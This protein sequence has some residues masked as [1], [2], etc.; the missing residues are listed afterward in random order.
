MA[1]PVGEAAW[2]S[3]LEEQIR[4]A[5]DL[6]QRVS[7]VEAFKRSTAA[8]PIS[9][10]LWLAYCS[11]IL[12]LY[13]DSRAEGWD[14]EEA[15]LGQQLFNEETVTDSW[16]EA[17]EA[18]KFRLS[19]SHLLWN[20]WIEFELER[21]E[22]S[23]TDVDTVR[24][25]F[26]DR[27]QVPQAAWD[28]T[29]RLFSN[30]V[31]KYDEAAYEETMVNATKGAAVGKILFSERETKEMAITRGDSDEVKEAMME[32]LDWEIKQ[33]RKKK[34]P[35]PPELCFALYERALLMFGTTV[36]LW[37]DYLSFLTTAIHHFF[38]NLNIL[39]VLERATKYCPSSGELWA[40]LLLRM[41]VE[42]LPATEVEHK[43]DLIP[44]SDLEMP[45]VILV[46]SAWLGY[47]RRSGGTEA[48][49]RGVVHS[50]RKEGERR[51]GKKDYKGDPAFTLER[52][53][54]QY[55]TE[56]KGDHDAARSEWKKLV[57]ARGDGYDFWLQYY[58]WELSVGEGS[59]EVAALVLASAVSR[60]M[61][62]W[63]EKLLEVYSR[64]CSLYQDA[65]TLETSLDF[66]FK[67]MKGVAKRRQKEAL[68]YQQQEPATMAVDNAVDESTPTSKRKR[69][70]FTAD[71]SNKKS[72]IAET[73]VAD[74]GGRNRESTSVLVTNLPPVTQTKVKLFFKD[75]GHINTIIMKGDK[76]LIEFRSIE[77][78][79]SAL[80]RN[81]K[82]FNQNQIQVSSG[83][84]LTLY[85]TNY[86]PT[87]DDAFMHALFSNCGE[88]FSIRWPSLK[89]N[90]HRRF[91]Y[92]SFTS[93][94]ATQKAIVE[95]DGKLLENGK[96]KLEVKY[97]DPTN[98]KS[99][100]GA[101]AEGRE[102]HIGSLD[103]T[104][105][106]DEISEIM[107]KYGKVESVRI[108]RNMAGNSK[109]GAF[110]VFSTQD[111]AKL[112]LEL[113]NTKFKSQ[114]LTVEL[115]TG[116]N[117][118]PKATTTSMPANGKFEKVS[119]AG[120]AQRT[121]IVRNI[122]DTVNDARIKA[123]AES[124]GAIVIKLTLRP[125][126]TGA[127]IELADEAMAGKVSL[128]LDGRE[129]DGKVLQVGA[130]PTPK[131]VLTS[132]PAPISV[133]AFM[134]QSSAPIKRPRALGGK[135]GRGG[136]AR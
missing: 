125:D 126:I 80:L 98:K 121:V 93:T 41:E 20:R 45:N 16:R 67:N 99:R 8:E 81:D 100:E 31:S 23:T 75:Y 61:L 114:I 108:L 24:K 71:V 76:A 70:E 59:Q 55:L 35:A 21:L 87:A 65:V 82:Y 54:I 14:E 130:P 129:L 63:P 95:L 110:V 116:I 74:I 115:S 22:K 83:Y 1:D 102:V 113:N 6:E 122:P 32:Y 66:A 46:Y 29:S 57:S 72:K 124:F 119:P 107:S 42:G 40:R 68:D 39:D 105:T 18:T 132:P 19:D 69:E 47:L 58:D 27:L 133:P 104:A 106:E 120:I 10:S 117:Y 49:V 25:L 7:V 91:C 86:P 101:T 2:L 127:S 112:S 28:E 109:G 34:D 62:D 4:S 88:I 15:E 73:L 78:A 85:I 52:S 96:Y 33:S 118:K 97:S 136:F 123:L 79:Q 5:N 11:Y 131:P 135:R 84:G 51:Y 128:G 103:R 17:S 50:A 44:L 9:I 94:E 53:L 92:I 111:E 77:D 56:V 12:S 26:L 38:E 60:R 3:Y 89:Y 13:N 36:S 90:A 64:H 134:Q 30:F 48:A 43:K 37:Q